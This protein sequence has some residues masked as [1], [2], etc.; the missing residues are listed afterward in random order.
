MYAFDGGSPRALLTTLA[1]GYLALLGPL[2][3]KEGDSATARGPYFK[4]LALLLRQPDASHLET[5]GHGLIGATPSCLVE[6]G[7][8][9][10]TITQ[11]DHLVWDVD[12]RVHVI[13]GHEARATAGRLVVDESAGRTTLHDPGIHVML[14]HVIEE[15]HWQ[16]PITQA[17]AIRILGTSFGTDT[18]HWSWWAVDT[19]V[20]CRQN[21][22]RERAAAPVTAI[23]SRTDAPVGGDRIVTRRSL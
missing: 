16:R 20:Q 15:L 7:E 13:A 9:R 17:G 12:V 18:A 11:P 1:E 19:R 10:T 5:G 3:W 6:V 22:W 8:G 2:Q 4:T 23:E 21:I 14:Q